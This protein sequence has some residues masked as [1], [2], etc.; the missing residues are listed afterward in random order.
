VQIPQA[1]FDEDGDIAISTTC[2]SS[3]E[4][5]PAAAALLLVGFAAVFTRRTPFASRFASR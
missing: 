4:V 3:G 1:G 2:S 5:S